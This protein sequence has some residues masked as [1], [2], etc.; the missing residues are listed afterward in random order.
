MVV[1]S[2]REAP[3]WLALQK[4]SMLFQD[5]YTLTVTGWCCTPD[6]F[7]SSAFRMEQV[8]PGCCLGRSFG[9]TPVNDWVGRKPVRFVGLSKVY[10]STFLGFSDRVNEANVEV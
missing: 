10:D 7:L 5:E 1:A 3:S 2:L 8:G 6:S 9:K 4:L